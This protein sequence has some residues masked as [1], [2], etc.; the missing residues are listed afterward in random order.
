[1]MKKVIIIA[2]S[3][4][5]KGHFIHREWYKVI[6]ARVVPYVPKQL[7]KISKKFSLFGHIIAIIN[8][9]FLPKADIYLLDGIGAIT[10][11]FFKPKKSKIISIN[12]DTFFRDLKKMNPIQRMISLFLIRK[13]NGFI[14]TSYMMKNLAEKYT[15]APNEVVYPF[16]DIKAFTAIKTK[17]KSKNIC[18][19]GMGS[20][21]GTKRLLEVFK[22]YKKVYPD[23]KLFIL[24]QWPKGDTKPPKKIKSVEYPGFANPVTYL[25]KCGVYINASTHESF[26][27][28]ILEA[29]AAGIPPIITQNCGAREIVEKIDPEL[30]AKADVEDIYKK[31]IKLILNKN[32]LNLSKKA[33]KL[34][35]GFS[36]EK[37]KKDFKKT[38]NELSEKYSK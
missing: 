6:N 1:M 28:N 16:I 18:A 25:K 7:L 11:T 22:K 33:R 3:G 5:G 32:L 27:A 20:A 23:S 8:S 12:S 19:I 36:I 14:S 26:G 30:I 4:S 31:T 24:G 9:L 17:L 38:F 37:S 10:A 15:D 13:I 29:M 35:K 2:F 21:K 34:A